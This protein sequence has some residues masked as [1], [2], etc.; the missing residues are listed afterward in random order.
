MISFWVIV[1]R[2]CQKCK[3][4]HHKIWLSLT[5]KTSM[6]MSWVLQQLGHT[7]TNQ[8]VNSWCFSWCFQQGKHA[9]YFTC[10][11][12]SPLHTQRVFVSWRRMSTPST[13]V[14]CKSTPLAG[15][16]RHCAWI[17]DW[18]I[19]SCYTVSEFKT[20]SLCVG[21]ETLICNANK[22]F[23]CG[24]QKLCKFQISFNKFNKFYS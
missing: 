5:N 19:S 14:V 17:S 23:A 13:Q 15:N 2:G 20:N 9:V 18:R 4:E 22:H 21:T 8:L 10:H 6:I 11:T 3:K 12:R 1:T 24:K 16:A 7:S